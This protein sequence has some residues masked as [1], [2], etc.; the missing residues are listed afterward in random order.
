MARAGPGPTTASI[1][2]CSASEVR[3]D[4]KRPRYRELETRLRQHT[5]TAGWLAG[6]P[7]AVDPVDVLLRRVLAEWIADPGENDAVLEL[8]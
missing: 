3:R 7:R 5:G 6:A 2:P 4:T 1:G 8:R